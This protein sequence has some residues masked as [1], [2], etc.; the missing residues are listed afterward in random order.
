MAESKSDDVHGDIS[1]PENAKRQRVSEND[2]ESFFGSIGGAGAG[3][4]A[5]EELSQEGLSQG[6]IQKLNESNPAL[7]GEAVGRIAGDNTIY[8][9]IGRMNPPTTGHRLL[10]KS[11]IERAL[12]EG[13]HQVNIILSSTLDNKKNLLEDDRKRGLLYQML[14]EP[15]D[16]APDIPPNSIFGELIEER[17]ATIEQMREF[18]VEIVCMDDPTD[19][20]FGRNPILKSLRYILSKYNLSGFRRREVKL[21]IGGDR[22]N[23]YD[24][25]TL[26]DNICSGIEIIA[27]E[28]PEG[29]MSATKIREYID[30]GDKAT[31]LESMR[32]TGISESNLEEIYNEMY[33]K[34]R[35][36]GGRKLRR[37]TRRRRRRTTRR[38][39]NPRGQ[40]T[41]RR[42]RTIRRRS[43]P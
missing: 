37:N 27:L 39:R 23:D 12:G 32:P 15:S 17:K 30:H 8:V 5:E 42:R 34:L 36:V 28:R 19:D 29:G 35:T 33:G 11:M 7:P 38:R 14:G 41:T 31:Y 21:M 1:E 13:L 40:R 20:S 4:E 6:D 16:I 24:W 25:V 22:A 43:F 3:A 9:T 10:I 26:P 18:H 2:G